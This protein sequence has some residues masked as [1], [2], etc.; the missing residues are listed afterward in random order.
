MACADLSVA[1]A[2]PFFPPL[3]GAATIGAEIPS[4]FCLGPLGTSGGLA[5]SDAVAGDAPAAFAARRSARVRFVSFSEALSPTF[6]LAFLSSASCFCRRSSS[7]SGV[8]LFTTLADLWVSQYLCF[9]LN[10]DTY[11]LGLQ[12]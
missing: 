6:R 12:A 3:P 2:L 10:V 4:T 1:T 5:L 8:I 11:A 7:K 9:S